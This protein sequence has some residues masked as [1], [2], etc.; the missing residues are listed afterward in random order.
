MYLDVL[1]PRV[2]LRLHTLYTISTMQSKDESKNSGH[3]NFPNIVDKRTSLVA[4]YTLALFTFLFCTPN[5]GILLWQGVYK[6][7]RPLR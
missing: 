4:W 3:S 1:Y 5:I 2:I 6:V 7:G